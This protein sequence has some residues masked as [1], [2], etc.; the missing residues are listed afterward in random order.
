MRACRFCKEGEG[1]LK[2]VGGN[3]REISGPFRPLSA[4]SPR[5][6]LLTRSRCLERLRFAAAGDLF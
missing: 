6:K 1:V 3:C 4:Y 2:G 5:R